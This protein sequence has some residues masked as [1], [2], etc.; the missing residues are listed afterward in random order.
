[1]GKTF[2]LVD[3]RSSVIRRESDEA[4]LNIVLRHQYRRKHPT[5]PEGEVANP[6]VNH[7]IHFIEGIKQASPRNIQLTEFTSVCYREPPKE[8]R[9][10]S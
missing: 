3:P 2:F 1:M 5:P 8:E 9:P 10:R 6:D 4:E 7:A